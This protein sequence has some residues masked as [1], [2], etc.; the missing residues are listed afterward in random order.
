MSRF[1][2]SN[3]E[4]ELDVKRCRESKEGGFPI[5]VTGRTEAGEIKA[6][7]GV[8]RSVEYLRQN[9]AETS[10]CITMEDVQ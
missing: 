9:P 2:V 4:P 8:V 10:W 6:F 5:T 7:T 1:Y 3:V